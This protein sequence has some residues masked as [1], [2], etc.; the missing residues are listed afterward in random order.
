VARDS[1][2]RA[3]AAKLVAARELALPV[4]LLDRP[5]APPGVPT[6]PTVTAALLW[7]TSRAAPPPPPPPPI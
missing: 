4:V 3:A 5:P 2:G 1:G 6:A 7:L